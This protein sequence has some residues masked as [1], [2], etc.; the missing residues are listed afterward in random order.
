MRKHIKNIIW[1][2]LGVF[3]LVV[4]NG[5]YS[6]ISSLSF[7]YSGIPATDYELELFDYLF[8]MSSFLQNFALLFMFVVMAF[9]II[10][11]VF[12][13]LAIKEHKKLT[14]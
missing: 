4:V 12:L 11:V 8:K 3:C 7:V 1:I 10:Q 13:I 6:G 5:L 14:F 9:T 2:V